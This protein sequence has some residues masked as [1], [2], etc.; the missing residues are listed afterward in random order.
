MKDSSH[1]RV[2]AI[3]NTHVGRE[4]EDAV[5]SYFES[6]GI[7][8]ARAFAVPVG[9]QCRTKKRHR[10]DLG[11]ENPPI[12]VECKAFTWAKSGKRPS[13]KIRSL[14]EAMFLFHL[15]PAHYRKLLVILRHMHPRRSEDSL[16]AH[17]IRTQSH[18]VPEGI[19]IWQFDL[20]SRQAERLL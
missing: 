20:L 18:L 19:E 2:G 5:Q 12:L 4:F 9:H 7:T 13:A 11:S 10:Y 8:L 14:N 1:Q 15:A 3:S 6:Q 17:Y 16:A